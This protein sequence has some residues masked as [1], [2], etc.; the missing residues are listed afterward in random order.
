MSAT[1]ETVDLL[2]VLDRR[3]ADRGDRYLSAYYFAFT[4][5]GDERIDRILAAIAAAGKSFHSTDGWT[6]DYTGE[7]WDYID[8][9]QAAANDAAQHG[10]S[11]GADDAR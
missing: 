1:G 6:D 11:N 9:I 3:I 7:G 8:L 2:A 4:A 5:T 10:S